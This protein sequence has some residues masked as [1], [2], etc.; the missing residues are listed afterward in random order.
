M[1]ATIKTKAGT[2][3]LRDYCGYV[4]SSFNNGQLGDGLRGYSYLVYQDR[5]AYDAGKG[6]ISAHRC[7]DRL[8][9]AKE[10]IDAL[11]K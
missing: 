2:E 5:A 10:F 6:A 3:V 7:L 11:C 4:I 1:I 8:S 9:E